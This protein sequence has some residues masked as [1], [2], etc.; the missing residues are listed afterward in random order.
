MLC[1]VYGTAE[2][3]W[4][5]RI[6]MTG[7]WVPASDSCVTASEGDEALMELGGSGVTE[8]DT[9]GRGYTGSQHSRSGNSLAEHH[10]NAHAHAYTQHTATCMLA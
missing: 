7:K 1:I 5:D 4:H 9:A 6:S 3:G 10:A 8:A 2:A